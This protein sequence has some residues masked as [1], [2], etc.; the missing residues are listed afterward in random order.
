MKK[1]ERFFRYTQVHVV[2]IFRSYNFDLYIK[3]L[4]L[5]LFKTY[6]MFSQSEARSDLTRWHNLIII[7]FIHGNITAIIFAFVK[8][9]T[10]Q[11]FENKIDLLI[12]N[13]I[14]FIFRHIFRTLINECQKIRAPTMT[15]ILLNHINR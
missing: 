3:Y 14:S 10:F 8:R 12:I 6:C 7:Y 13:F 9:I 11:M 15:L 4:L 2:Y 1:S 5:V